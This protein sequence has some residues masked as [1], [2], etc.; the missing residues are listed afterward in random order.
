MM[1]PKGDQLKALS[2]GYKAQC[3]HIQAMRDDDKSH[4]LWICRAEK[5]DKSITVLNCDECALL[6]DKVTSDRA[7]YRL[8]TQKDM[9]ESIPAMVQDGWQFVARTKD[10]AEGF[11]TGDE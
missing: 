1:E 11:C 7:P 2:G 8:E 6:T 10:G 3:I 9:N 4:D 5:G